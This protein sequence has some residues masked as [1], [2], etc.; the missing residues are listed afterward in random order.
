MILPNWVWAFPKMGSWQHSQLSLT[1]NPLMLMASTSYW[2]YTPA[3]ASSGNRPIGSLLFHFFPRSD[4]GFPP[5]VHHC[6][7]GWRSSFS[8]LGSLPLGGLQPW[9]HRSWR[10]EFLLLTVEKWF[11]KSIRR[12]VALLPIS[13]WCHPVFF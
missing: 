12:V 4:L 6:R 3:W 1:L 2:H 9:P 7:L 10:K 8:A 13:P 11:G 5:V